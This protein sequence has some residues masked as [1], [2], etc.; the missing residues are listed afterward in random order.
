MAKGW[1]TLMC[2]EGYTALK[3]FARNK[4]MVNLRIGS[5]SGHLFYVYA[6]WGYLFTRQ[7]PAQ[8]YFPHFRRPDLGM[9][10]ND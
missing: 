2:I 9:F 1:Q 8:K 5:I 3:H 4:P 6:T 10:E 7:G